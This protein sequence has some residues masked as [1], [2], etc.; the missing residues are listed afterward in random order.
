MLWVVE[1]KIDADE[2]YEQLSRYRKW[3]D[4]Q[5]RYRTKRLFFLTPDGRRAETLPDECDYTRLSYQNQI[6][7]WITATIPRI[8]SSKVRAIV[9]QHL[10]VIQHLEVEP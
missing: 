8:R 6:T 2:G 5:S 4:S 7:R 1:N 10:E 9:E 3:L